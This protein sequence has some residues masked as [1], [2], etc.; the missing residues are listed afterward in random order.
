V[1]QGRLRVSIVDDGCGVPDDVASATG[2]GLRIMRY[3]A[4]I[5]RGDVRVERAEPTGTRV[6]F[7]GALST[8]AASPDA[9]TN[10]HISN[11]R[12]AGR[13]SVRPALRSAAKRASDGAAKLVSA[14]LKSRRRV[15]GEQ[16]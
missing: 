1:T 7:D 10:S 8:R 9:A 2:M 12:S 5:A 14:P 3:R 13:A 16:Q 15:R 4:R 11:V 6:V